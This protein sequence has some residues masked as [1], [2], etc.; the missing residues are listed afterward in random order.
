MSSDRT[1]EGLDERWFPPE[2]DSIIPLLFGKMTQTSEVLCW[3]AC[4]GCHQIRIMAERA[5][6][7]APRK[8]NCGCSIGLIIGMSELCS[9]DTTKAKGL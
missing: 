9:L 6:E 7:I 3:G 8:K 4:H 1:E 2:A 5:M